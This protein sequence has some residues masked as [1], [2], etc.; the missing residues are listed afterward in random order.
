MKKQSITQLK[1]KADAVFSLYVRH[2]DKGQCITCG[3]IKAPKD[4]Q[5]G[6]FVSR[7]H[8]ATRYDE[9]NVNCQCVA[10]NV[11]MSGNMVKYA[12]ALM[13][14]Y[15]DN[16]VRELDERTS[17]T[18]QLKKADYLAIIEAYKIN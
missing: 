13:D 4:M 3:V 2:R 1:K 8:L 6:H 9:W 5:A 17:K 16:V 10:C 7:R 14:K 11:F 15:G 18:A 12:K